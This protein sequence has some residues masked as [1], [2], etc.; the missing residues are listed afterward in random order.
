M[1]KR[2]LPSIIVVAFSMLLMACG[3][4]PSNQEEPKNKTETADLPEEKGVY[5]KDDILKIDNAT[6]KLTG[7]EIAPPDTEIGEEKSTLIITYD[8][9]NDSDKAGQPGIVWIACFTAT[10][11]TDTTIDTLDVAP[12]PRDEKY[13]EMNDMSFTDIKPGATVS[14]VI[15]YY[16]NDTARPITL[17]AT[18]GL[19]GKDL[20][21][22]IYKLQ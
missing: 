15:S 7:F 3:T 14:A 10:Q 11:E 5:F 6:I 9:T 4:S 20:G 8:Y 18:Q 12:S 13:K 21:E 2:F 22:K 19:T 16:I 1:K 17:K